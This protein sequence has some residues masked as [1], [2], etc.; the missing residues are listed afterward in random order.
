LRI[1][2]KKKFEND[3]RGIRTCALPISFCNLTGFSG[4]I[5]GKLSEFS[6]D[7]SCNTP[8]LHINGIPVENQESRSVKLKNLYDI[9]YI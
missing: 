5:A 8:S 3:Y 4:V 7:M 6:V 2:L 1:E 9:F